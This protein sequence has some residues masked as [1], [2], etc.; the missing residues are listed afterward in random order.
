MTI[1]G[2]GCDWCNDPPL[3]DSRV[4][5]PA[6]TLLIVENVWG[7][8]D[9]HAGWLYD[10][11]GG[12]YS[13]FGGCSIDVNDCRETSPPGKGGRTN[14]IYYDGHVKATKWEQ[15]WQPRR[16]NQ[17]TLS[18]RVTPPVFGGGSG[19]PPGCGHDNPDPPEVARC[20]R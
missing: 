20:L 3:K 11:C 18:G 6:E 8:A 9:V 19:A 5:R 10:I 7:T 17:W 16:V 2:G 4:E 15:T 14:A 12:V 13:H 1:N